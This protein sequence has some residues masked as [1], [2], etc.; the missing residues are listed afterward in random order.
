MRIPKYRRYTHDFKV[1]AVRKFLRLRDTLSRN[2]ITKLDFARS[3]NVPKS[4]FCNWL[5]A[6][7]ASDRSKDSLRDHRCGKKPGRNADKKKVTPQMKSI[8]KYFKEHLNLGCWIIA[9]IIEKTLKVPIS[10][11]TVW[12]IE[13]ELGLNKK[14]KKTR[15]KRFRADAPD[16]LWQIDII[17]DKK[18]ADGVI[19]AIT[20][21]DDYSRYTWVQVFTQPPTTSDVISFLNSIIEKEGSSP[22]ALLTDHGSVFGNRFDIWCH[23]NKMRKREFMARQREYLQ[24]ESI[25]KINSWWMLLSYHGIFH[26]RGRVRHPQTQGK[27][28]RVHRELNK[29]IR[30]SVTIEECERKIHEMVD[31]LNYY[32]KIREY[33]KTP[34][35]MYGRHELPE[36][37]LPP[38]IYQAKV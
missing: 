17:G 2:N 4:T 10:H 12:K 27:V 15:Y 3:I 31:I 9:D 24:D 22:F 18:M 29:A 26:I 20:V 16:D 11:Q 33:K 1:F 35:E 38:P 7:E 19:Y 34:A 25:V 37:Y 8:V 6:Y 36:L 32:R 30:A 28:E 13:K 14:Q 5:T 21:T 23:L